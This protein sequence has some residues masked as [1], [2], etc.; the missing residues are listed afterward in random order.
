MTATDP[1]LQVDEAR[2]EQFAGR[3]L[4]TFTEGMV[5]LMIDLA[6][7]TGLLDT[8]AAGAGTSQQLAERAD[9]AERYVRECLGALV[10]AG[11]VD[12]SPDTRTYFLPAEHAA[13]LSGPGALNLA[14]LSQFTTLLANHVGD[15]ARAFRDGGGVP[16]DAFRP[17]F[18]DVMDAASRGLM[19]GQL[20]DGIVPLAAGLPDRLNEGIRVADIGC[21]TGHALNLL[22]R[23]HPRSTFVGYD[24]STD[25][26]EAA[27]REAAAW[28]LRN[29]SF[30]A[31]DVAQLEAAPPFDAVFAFDAIHD[32][33]EPVRVLERVR[34]ALAPGGSS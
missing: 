15:V 19:D 27:R 34:G 30:E 11:I 2:V 26:I 6:Y 1:T 10:T 24:I 7:R 29:V 5:T 4:Q 22:A 9:L 31:L 12:Y 25:A 23:A 16:Y 14:P 13:C 18:T 8:L 21:G 3:L 20:L 28:G 32:Q 17:E 33:A